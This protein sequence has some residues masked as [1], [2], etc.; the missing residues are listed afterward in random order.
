MRKKWSREELESLY[1]GNGVSTYGI[2]KIRGCSEDT[3]LYHMEKFGIPRRSKSEAMKGYYKS[4]EAREKVSKAMRGHSVSEETRRKITEGNRGKHLSEETRRKISEAEKGRVSPMKGKHQ[5]EEAKQKL[6]EIRLKQI[7]PRKDTS[8]E[9]AL[10]NGLRERGIAFE[11]H[12]PI[13][14]QPDIF[15]EPNICIFA[16]G[17]YWHS[18]PEVK[19]RDA[20]VNRIL[21]ERGYRVLRFWEHEIN[22]NLNACLDMIEREVAL[23][24][25]LILVGG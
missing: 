23:S 13:Y 7:F 18:R 5:S 8:I 10:Q 25:K 11:T 24:R 16:D 3:V 9:V 14:G 19:E 4:E 6:R 15:I 21:T 1:W 2:A 12:K 20:E 17:E 22:S